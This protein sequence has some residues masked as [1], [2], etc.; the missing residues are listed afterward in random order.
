MRYAQLVLPVLALPLSGAR[1]ADAGDGSVSEG[2]ANTDGGRLDLA[3]EQDNVG[4]CP[5]LSGVW[6]IVAHCQ[7]NLIGHTVVIT[8]DGCSVVDTLRFKG[9]IT[10]DGSFTSTSDPPGTDPTTCTGTATAH[11]IALTCTGLHQPCLVRL[12]R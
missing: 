12:M 8:Q 5:D 1:C 2:S 3:A 9:L 11:A 7:S 10:V 6:T 4:R